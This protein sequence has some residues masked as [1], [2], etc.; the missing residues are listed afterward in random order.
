MALVRPLVIATALLT[1]VVTAQ[2]GS[3]IT[4]A[5]PTETLEAAWQMRDFGAATEFTQVTIDG[6]PAIRA[7]GRNSASGLYRTVDLRLAEHPL[8]QWRWR[9]DYLQANA[10]LRE[11]DA[12]DFA[13][14]IFLIFGELGAADSRALGYVWTNDRLAPETVVRSPRHPEQVRSIVVESGTRNLGQW[15]QEDRDVAADFRS[16]FGRDPPDQVR[17]VALFTD[18]DQTAEPVEAYYGPIWALMR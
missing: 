10:D 8:L 3:S 18:N 14:A 9:V 16:A 4:I 15:L 2:A 5:D 13:A 6:V 11:R 1:V 12:E 17:T 7:V